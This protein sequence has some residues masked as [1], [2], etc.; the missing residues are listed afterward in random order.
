VYDSEYRLDLGGGVIARLLWLGAA[1]TRGDE[2]IFVDPDRTLISGDV[3]QNKIAPN[4]AGEGG[5]PSSWVAVI[6]RIEPLGAL[7]VMPDHSAIGDGS[8]VAEEKAFILDL[9]SRALEL[10]RQGIE[11]EAAGKMLAAQFQSRYPEWRLNSVPAFV[12]RI[13]ADAP[14]DIPAN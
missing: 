3:V 10:K 6:D 1:H 12:E 13:Y 2:L 8:L 14:A 9:R 4:I 7:K 5:T 11:S